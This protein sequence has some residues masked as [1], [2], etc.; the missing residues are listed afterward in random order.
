M[1]QKLLQ[2]KKLLTL[3]DIAPNW[4]RS[5]KMG[6]YNREELNQNKYCVVG[7]AHGYADRY[8]CAECVNYSMTIFFSAYSMG[9]N[10]L[11]KD[12]SK[13]KQTL[14]DFVDHWNE[15]HVTDMGPESRS[16]K[17]VL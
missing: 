17:A 4:A 16:R 1:N 5:I 10:D 8:G 14:T 15:F 2:I 11:N 9:C 12:L 7:E 6:D 3:E 13:H